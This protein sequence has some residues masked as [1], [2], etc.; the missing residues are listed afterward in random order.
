MNHEWIFT[1]SHPDRD[2]VSIPA[3]G[4]SRRQRSLVLRY[5]A[6]RFSASCAFI[7]IA[8][9]LGERAGRPYGLKKGL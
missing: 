5:F 9:M 6:H 2:L 3:P 1:S 4:E 7:C 8:L